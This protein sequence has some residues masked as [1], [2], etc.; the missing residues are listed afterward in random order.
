MPRW[1]CQPETIIELEIQM[2][3]KIPLKGG[4]GPM[5]HVESKQIGATRSLK[6]HPRAINGTQKQAKSDP[7]AS[8]DPLQM[9]EGIKG[10]KRGLSGSPQGNQ[11]SP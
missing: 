8:S 2:A 10:S 4:N 1:V 9:P 5:G 3:S 6:G 7:K 11:V